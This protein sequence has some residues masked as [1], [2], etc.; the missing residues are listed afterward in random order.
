MFDLCPAGYLHFL[1]DTFCLALC[2]STCQFSVILCVGGFQYYQEINKLR[3]IHLELNI[4]M[5]LW[6]I[7]HGKVMCAP[8]T[9]QPSE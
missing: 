2:D 3:D 7:K 8:R 4:Y 6:K 9:E 5:Y 1:W